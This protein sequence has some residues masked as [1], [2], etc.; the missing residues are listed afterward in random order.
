[1]KAT[2]KK[3]IL[4]AM[5]KGVIMPREDEKIEFT[6]VYGKTHK[7]Y[8]IKDEDMFFIG[9]GLTGDFIYSFDVHNWKYIKC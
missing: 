3:K 9:Y 4:S 6:D 7:G 2:K 5:P 8:Y 1:M